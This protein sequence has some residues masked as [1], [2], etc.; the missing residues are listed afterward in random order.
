MGNS[1]LRTVSLALATAALLPGC[2]S[3]DRPAQSYVLQEVAF[4]DAKSAT[5]RIEAECQ[6]VPLLERSVI[7]KAAGRGIAIT[8]PSGG[9]APE[10]GEGRLRVHIADV[11][12]AQFGNVFGGKW[13]VSDM[14]VMVS[15]EDGKGAREREVTCRAGLGANPFANL[16]ACDRLKRCTD[17][18]GEW[19]SRW[20]HRA[21]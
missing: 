8:K 15:V 18:I 16:T 3:M 7:D 19:T 21:R 12:G 10:A 13:V 6:L 17:Y 1:R 20:L 14:V 5:P 2:R 11:I 9:R 4:L